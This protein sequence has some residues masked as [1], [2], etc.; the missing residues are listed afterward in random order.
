MLKD[1]TTKS[2]HRELFQYISDNKLDLL[3]VDETHFGAR[4]EKYGKILKTDNYNND[5]KSEKDDDY[6]ETSVADKIVKKIDAKVTI[7]LS[8][9]PYRILKD[10]KEF[11]AED[12]IAFYTFDDLIATQ[13]QWDKTNFSKPENEQ[14][15]ECDN[16]YYG[17]PEMIRFAFYP[18]ESSHKKLQE[19]KNQGITYAFSALLKPKSITKKMMIPTKSLYMKMRYMTGLKPSTAVT[20]IRMYSAFSITTKSRKDKCATI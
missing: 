3:L 11:K 10:K 13:R 6:I 7:H 8:G 12:I 1:D 4:A 16:P 14:M 9:T 20:K 2:R 17:F 15:E 18:N 19:L 5:V